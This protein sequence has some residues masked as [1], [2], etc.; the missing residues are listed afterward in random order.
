MRQPEHAGIPGQ[1]VLAVDGKL[2]GG[3]SRSRFWREVASVGDIPLL[4]PAKSDREPSGHRRLLPRGKTWRTNL[5]SQAS[6][7]T[8]LLHGGPHHEYYQPLDQRFPLQLSAQLLGA[9]F[10]GRT[11][12][13]RSRNFAAAAIARIGR[14]SATR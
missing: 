11:G 10:Y 3:A 4:Q 8:L 13:R 12:P 6:T 7:A 5:H 2:R 1:L 14:S 9:V